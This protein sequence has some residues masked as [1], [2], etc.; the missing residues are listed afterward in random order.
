MFSV[1]PVVDF[2]CVFI[3]TQA[4]YKYIWIKENKVIFV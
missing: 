1:Y 4:L 2:S 3:A